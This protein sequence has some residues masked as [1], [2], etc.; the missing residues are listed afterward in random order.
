MTTNITEE[1]RHAFQALTG[2][3]AN[4]VCL[5]GCFVSR[6]PSASIAVVN[7]CQPFEDGGKPEYLISPPFV[8][9]TPGIRL[10]DHDGRE[11]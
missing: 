5:F 3:E 7:V 9:T 4:N 8:G 2:G 6:E 1:H 10:V 11:A